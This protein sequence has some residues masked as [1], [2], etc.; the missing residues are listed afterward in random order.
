[1]SGSRP[2]VYVISLLGTLGT[3][4]EA[5]NTDT[6]A[7]AEAGFRFNTDGTTDIRQGDSYTLSHDDWADPASASPGALYEIRA[8]KSSGSES[9]L[10]TGTLN[11]WQALSSN[12]TYE[13]LNNFQN[14]STMDIVLKIEVRDVATQTIQDTGYYKLEAISNTVFD[15]TPNAISWTGISYDAVDTTQTESTST[16]TITGI[17]TT[18]TLEF[19]SPAITINAGV[20]GATAS[21]KVL[22]NAGTVA[23]FNE[24]ELVSFTVTNNDTIQFEYTF[25]VGSETDATW[26]GTTTIV[27]TSDGDTTLDAIS[28]SIRLDDFTGS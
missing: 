15:K 8:T 13:L 27:N 20:G 21:G 5:T 19:T 10:S 22:V 17:D 2:I 16:E 28:I 3:P 6:D 11:S 25:S 1:M 14:N 18:L 12:R 4:E 7:R 23:T 9:S 26:S 24:A